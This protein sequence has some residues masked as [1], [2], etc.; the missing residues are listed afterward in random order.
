MRIFR[1]ILTGLF[2]FPVGLLAYDESQLVWHSLFGG[3]DYDVGRSIALDP[4]GYYVVVGGTKSYGAG[5]YDYWILKIDPQTGDTVWSR[6]Y[7]GAAYDY[8]YS[9]A[10]DPEGYYVVNGIT[11]SFGNGYHDFWILKLDPATGDTIWSRTYGGSSFDQGSAILVDDEGYYVAIGHTKS[12]GTAESYDAWILK[13]DP[14]TGDTVWAAMYGGSDYDRV[15]GITT[16]GSTYIVVGYEESPEINGDSSRQGWIFKINASD[17]SLVWMKSYGGDEYEVFSDVEVDPDGYIVVA[18]RT[19]SFS[20]GDRDAWLLKMDPATGDTLWTTVVGGGSDD[21]LYGLAI[22]PHGNYV[23]TGY[24]YSFAVGIMDLW[25]IKFDSQSGDTLWTATFGADS[26]DRGESIV[27][28]DQGYIAITGYTKSYGAV[29]KDVWVLRLSGIDI[30]S[31]VV[32]SLS[33]L[34]RDTTGTARQVMVWA[35]D[36][37]SGVESVVLYYKRGSDPWESVEMVP[38][39]GGWY[40]G[41]IPPLALPADSVEVE[42]FAYAVDSAGNGASSDTL[43]Y[44]LVNPV[45]SIGEDSG[46]VMRLENGAILLMGIDKPTV[47]EVFDV[48]GRLVRRV[49][50]IGEQRIKLPAGVYVIKIGKTK[51]KIV[52]R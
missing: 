4:D 46:V 13:L 36:D 29:K 20:A 15:F 19:V 1:Y 51:H 18:G 9:V 14:A 22:D 49:L 31:P 45:V 35:V 33:Q 2:I 44:W 10:V 7:G 24:T 40:T 21:R 17:G 41:Q 12:Y 16:D 8:A 37:R 3:Y 48:R 6:V 50:A 25:V 43:S 27:I 28:D 52:V 47:V 23:A 42:Y 38:G 5:N 39:S 26:A 11:Q 30:V 34:D 32:D